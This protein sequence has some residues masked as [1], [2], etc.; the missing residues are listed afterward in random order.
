MPSCHS[1]SRSQVRRRAGEVGDP[2]LRP[3]G[4]EDTLQVT[5]PGRRIICRRKKRLPFNQGYPFFRGCQNRIDLNTYLSTDVQRIIAQVPYREVERYVYDGILISL[6]ETDTHINLHQLA[7]DEE[8]AD[9]PI[10]YDVRLQDILDL[11]SELEGRAPT[12]IPDE[13]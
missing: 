12:D 8:E 1:S 5:R 2:G 10:D 6:A 11:I 7:L 4:K 9:D 3:Q 13:L